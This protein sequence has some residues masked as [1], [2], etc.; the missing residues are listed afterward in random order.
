MELWR[1]LDLVDT[2]DTGDVTNALDISVGDR[3]TAGTMDAWRRTVTGW[4][5]TGAS[6]AAET[7]RMTGFV[8]V[9][10]YELNPRC[11]ATGV[12]GVRAALSNRPASVTVSVS[13]QKPGNRSERR[14]RGA[15]GGSIVDELGLRKIERGLRMVSSEPD[16]EPD[17]PKET[18]PV[19]TEGAGIS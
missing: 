16:T 8:P 15:A 3:T 2:G 14:R 19:R 12:V 6:R 10:I 11:L 9:G 5:T 18:V 17:D 1:E 13:D 4:R 7:S